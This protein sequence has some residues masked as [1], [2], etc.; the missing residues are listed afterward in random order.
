MNTI[1]MPAQIEPTRK[2]LPQPGPSLNFLHQRFDLI[3]LAGILLTAN[4]HLFTGKTNYFMIFFPR[5][6]VE[7]QWWRIF[8]HPFVHFTWYHFFLDAGAFV[9]LYTG[10][11]ETRISRK[12]VYLATSGAGSLI[13]V[14]LTEPMI[15][16]KGL[17]GLSGIA[18]GLMAVSA[19][20]MLEQNQKSKIG[21][22]CFGV[23]IFKS[24]YETLSGHVLFP[25]LLLGLCGTPLEVC[26]AGGVIGGL[27]GYWILRKVER[28][29]CILCS[30]AVQK[31]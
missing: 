21:W 3:L 24:I 27:L 5:A 19:L 28:S 11:M 6:V 10:L 20:E 12:M 7:G 23:I 2:L 9:L 14:L 29:K 15:Y 26:H 13:A 16:S 22:V 1:E 17:G 30:C 8:T 25:F 31:R 4:Y 18:H